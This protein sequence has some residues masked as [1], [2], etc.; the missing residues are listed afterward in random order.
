MELNE[1][2]SRRD[3]VANML[4][5]GAAGAA[6]FALAACTNPPMTLAQSGASPSPMG[7]ASPMAAASPSMAQMMADKEA[8]KKLLA[9]GADLEFQAIWAYTTAA[10]TK[11]LDG[12]DAISKAVKKLALKNAADHAEHAKILNGALVAMGGTAVTA[13]SDYLATVKPF[14]DGG[15]GNLDDLAGIARLALALEVDAA[16]AYA[17]VVAGF[18]SPD[19]LKAGLTILPDESAHCAAIR[20]L[21]AQ[22]GALTGDIVPAATLSGNN[23]EAWVIKA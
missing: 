2:L 3:F 14:I 4:K 10:A 11:K 12:D 23:R 18:K 8:D 5:V 7:A 22:A 21:L 20:A 15:Y 13:K 6:G 16:L 17:G 1:D 9:I 19:L